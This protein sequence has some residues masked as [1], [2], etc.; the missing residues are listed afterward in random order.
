MRENI[1]EQ[2]AVHPK[3]MVFVIAGSLSQVSPAAKV[4][5]PF[6]T[7]PQTVKERP[8]LPTLYWTMAADCP[9]VSGSIHTGV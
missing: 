8:V 3:S 7:V 6:K 9:E 1:T 5:T 2:P 4:N